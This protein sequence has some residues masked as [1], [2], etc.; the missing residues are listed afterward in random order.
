MDS[1]LKALGLL[2]YIVLSPL[3][4]FIEFI[5]ESF[6]F[7]KYIGVRLAKFQLIKPRHKRQVISFL[8]HYRPHIRWSFK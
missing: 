4:A 7:A 2:L 6:V 5:I 3:F 8:K 1:L